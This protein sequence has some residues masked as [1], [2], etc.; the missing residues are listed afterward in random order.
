[1]QIFFIL[2][3]DTPQMQRSD[4]KLTNVLHVPTR[5]SRVDNYLRKT[6]AIS[7][8]RDRVLLRTVVVSRLQRFPSFKVFFESHF[9]L[10]DGGFVWV[11]YFWQHSISY[12]YVIIP[13]SKL[14]RALKLSWWRH[15]V[16]NF[17][18]SKRSEDVERHNMRPWR[19]LAF[20]GACLLLASI[21]TQVIRQ[22][23]S[24]SEAIAPKASLHSNPAE[25]QG[26]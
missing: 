2:P 1:M 18:P 15:T 23:K 20:A 26:K 21:S 6:R 11:S 17:H 5:R 10:W 25:T 14:L 7:S 8:S 24:V 22:E 9:H 12:D 16:N 19:F 3:E 13:L 4:K